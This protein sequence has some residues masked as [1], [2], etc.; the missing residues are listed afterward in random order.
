MRLQLTEHYDRGY[1]D[2]RAG[3]LHDP[4]L[5]QVDAKRAYT[6]GFADSRLTDRHR[7]T[8]E[9]TPMPTTK[10]VSQKKVKR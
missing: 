4:G 8:R 2:G 3:N 1:A 6:A 9:L 5:V 7:M 10:S